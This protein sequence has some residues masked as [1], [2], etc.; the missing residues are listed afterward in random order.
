[1][2]PRTRASFALAD[3]YGMELLR[4]KTHLVFR[5]PLGFHFSL[6]STPSDHRSLRNAESALRLRIRSLGGSLPSR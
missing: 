2:N 1:M 3:R 6:P 4:R 5:H